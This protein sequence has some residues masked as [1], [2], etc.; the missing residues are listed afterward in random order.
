MPLRR[1]Y[2]SSPGGRETCFYVQPSGDLIPAAIE[3]LKWVLGGGALGAKQ[4]GPRTRLA[5][6]VHEIGPKGVMI[7]PASTNLARAMREADIPVEMIKVSRRLPIIGGREPDLDSMLEARYMVPLSRFDSDAK[8]L[9]TYSIPFI[10]DGRAALEQLNERMSFGW[11]AEEIHAIFELCEALGRD[12]TILE[13]VGVAQATSE[14]CSHGFFNATMELDG[15]LQGQTL[16]QMVKEPL[17]LL[18]EAGRLR[19]KIAF[20]DNAAAISIDGKM[21]MLYTANPGQPSIYIYRDEGLLC[22]LNVG[23]MGSWGG[24]GFGFGSIVL[25]HGGPFR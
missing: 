12:P 22:T 1:F 2:R 6:N 20:S 16:F 15:I 25:R 18:G 13:M 7:T 19:C 9:A 8:P 24:T 11:G 4:L 17:S 5:G 23:V 14:H 21:P 3:R 10:A